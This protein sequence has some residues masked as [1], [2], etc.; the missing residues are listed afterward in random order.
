MENYNTHKYSEGDPLYGTW[1]DDW[2]LIDEHTELIG[3]P[4]QHR[5]FD[6]TICIEDYDE[7]S[8]CYAQFDKDDAYRPKK[9]Y[10]CAEKHCWICEKCF[11]DF[12]EHFHWKVEELPDEEVRKDPLGR[13]A[14]GFE[15]IV[16]TDP[17]TILVCDCQHTVR[18]MNKAAMDRFGLHLFNHWWGF[19]FNRADQEWAP[20]KQ[21][22]DA[23]RLNP[24]ETDAQTFTM[25]G[26]TLK[27]APLCNRRRELM[28][29]YLICP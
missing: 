24:G 1:E 17:R 20:V 8:F 27:M 19:A 29:Y 12:N 4:L 2:R 5:T 13:L 18:Y 7:C 22:F 16:D 14:A 3:L 10:Y 6:R 25:N 21:I 23:F 26:T 9:A 15:A 28:G 11:D